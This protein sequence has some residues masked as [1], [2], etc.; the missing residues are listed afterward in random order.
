MPSENPR[1]SSEDLARKFVDGVL[2]GVA[3]K[4]PPCIGGSK[5]EWTRAVFKVLD[6]L[7]QKTIIT[8]IVTHG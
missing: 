7:G 6:D 3:D 8:I 5:P 1:I 2:N 4:R